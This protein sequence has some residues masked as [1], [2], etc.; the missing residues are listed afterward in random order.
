MASGWENEVRGYLCYKMMTYPQGPLYDP[1]MRLKIIHKYIVFFPLRGVPPASWKDFVSWYCSD[2]SLDVGEKWTRFCRWIELNYQDLEN[3]Y[4]EHREYYG[5]VYESEIDDGGE[6]LE[7]LPPIFS[8]KFMRIDARIVANEWMLSKLRWPWFT[9]PLI[10]RL[11]I[12][13]DY[14]KH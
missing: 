8:Y 6:H 14:L 9:A 10:L 1:S 12:I 5:S 3:K 11:L 2:S 7:A 13:C 4:D